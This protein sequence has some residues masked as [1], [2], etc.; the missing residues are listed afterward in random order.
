M[1]ITQEITRILTHSGNLYTSCSC[2]GLVC[3]FFTYAI[4][5]VCFGV[6]CKGEAQNWWCSTVLGNICRLSQ[7]LMGHLRVDKTCIAET[8]LTIGIRHGA[9]IRRLWPWFTYS[10]LSSGD[11]EGKV[12]RL[13]PEVGARRNL[14]ACCEN[15][16]GY[17]VWGHAR[18]NLVPSNTDF[19]YL[20]RGQEPWILWV[21]FVTPL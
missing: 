16:M 6:W 14:F 10:S 1:A 17:N 15:W 19:P 2:F 7:A 21:A 9:W 20:L 18:Q 4:T 13:L 12:N 11:C 3:S 5:H 8:S